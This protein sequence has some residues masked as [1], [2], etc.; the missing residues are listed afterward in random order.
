VGYVASISDGDTR[1]DTDANTDPQG[2]LKLYAKPWAWLH[3]S[4]SGLLSG[5]IGR[6]NEAA[7]GALWLG[8]TWA[9]AIGSRTAGPTFVD[10]LPVPDG[11]NVIT[12]TWLAG[13]DVVLT[14]LDGLRVWL[15]GGR[16]HIEARGSGSYDRDLSY[17]IAE[18]VVEGRLLSPALDPLYLGLRANGLTT[19]DGARGYLLDARHLDSLG[20]NMRNLDELSAVLG[21]RIGRHVRVRGEYAFQNVDLVRGVTPDIASRIDDEHWF[22][23]DVAISF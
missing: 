16:Y 18:I 7:P 2:T 17:W 8:E 1:F 9:M 22:A 4:M 14:P 12:H 5:A 23:L 15:A 10:G 11:P 3:V 6:T 19:G 20:F 13:A 21:L